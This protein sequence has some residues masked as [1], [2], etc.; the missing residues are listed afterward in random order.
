MRPKDNETL[1]TPE[2]L[3]HIR[4]W[5]KLI[6]TNLKEKVLRE[7][8]ANN[9]KASPQDGH[10]LVLSVTMREH[11][12]PQVSPLEHTT[13]YGFKEIKSTPM[14]RLEYNV[15]RGWKLPENECGD[16][17]GYLVEYVDSPNSN[18]P[19][20]AGY[21]SWSP[22]EVHEGAYRSNADGLTFGMATEAARRGKRIARRG[23]NGSG[24]FA[25]IVP[26]NHYPATTDIAK[27]HFGEGNLVPYREYWA[28][29]TAQGDVA[30]WAPSGSDSLATDW[31]VLD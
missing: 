19:G 21:I 25:Y 24:M 8:I 18:H 29:K 10:D 13:Y 27:N 5:G 30:T 3:E 23:W 14:T 15:L 11:Q 4:T 17:P 20:Y 22:K 26:A 28:L 1:A 31:V 12:R 2:V 7:M 6:D 9:Q 16:D